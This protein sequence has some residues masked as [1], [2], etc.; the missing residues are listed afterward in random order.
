[1]K[2]T[3]I[4]YI[5]AIAFGISF[6]SNFASAE[7]DRTRLTVKW[8]QKVGMILKILKVEAEEPA[9]GQRIV[10]ITY[11]ALNSCRYLSI[12]GYSYSS[13][14]VQLGAVRLT[15]KMDFIQGQKFRD[16][17]VVPYEAGGYIVFDEAICRNGRY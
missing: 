15:D 1:M 14:G 9:Y 2:K 5:T 16:S 10:R 3:L 7:N 11:E 13:D 4:I 8:N 6:L 12:Y 17:I